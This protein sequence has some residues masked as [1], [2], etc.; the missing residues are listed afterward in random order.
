[1]KYTE[2][3]VIKSLKRKRN[4][5]ICPHLN[6]LVLLKK[7]DGNQSNGNKTLG[8]VSF[9]QNYCDYKIRFIEANSVGIREFKKFKCEKH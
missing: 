4:I 1:M 8:K 3:K 7:A 9:L 2:E 6:I 5:K